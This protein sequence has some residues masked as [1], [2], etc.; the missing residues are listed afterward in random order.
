MH[1]V[2]IAQDDIKRQFFIMSSNA[3][4]STNQKKVSK[5]ITNQG[6]S[7]IAANLFFPIGEASDE[8]E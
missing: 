8:G 7:R 2:R 5:P 3:G 6:E 4:R 1:E